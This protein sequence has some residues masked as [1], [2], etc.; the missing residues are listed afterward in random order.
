MSTD[1]LKPSPESSGESSFAQQI[2][3]LG[4]RLLIPLGLAL[5]VLVALAIYAD[6]RQVMERLREF[7]FELLPL[8]LALSLV[9]YGLRFGRWQLYLRRLDLHLPVGRSLL[10][11]LVGFVLSITPGKVGELGK[12]WMVREMDGGPARRAVAAVLAERITDLLSVFLL[13]CLGSLA[14]PGMAAIA[15]VGLGLT[16]AAV[17]LLAWPPF[18]G[19]LVGLLAKI[20]WLAQ[21]VSILVDI[22]DHL[23]LLLAPG[24]LF[25]GLILGGLAWGAEG[26]GFALVVSAYAPEASWLAGV[27]NYSLGSLAGG[28]AMLPGGLLATEGVLTALL[29][30]QGLTASAAASATLIVRAATLWFAVGLGLIALPFAIRIIRRSEPEVIEADSERPDA[31]EW[32]LLPIERLP[33]ER[34]LVEWRGIDSRFPAGA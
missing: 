19:R 30:S 20:D 2:S 31:P 6:A 5:L 24:P 17:A 25:A 32:A 23:R 7:D 27:F 14:F 8:V 12:A 1:N 28:L 16:A 29:G 33:I 18:V 4:R 22:Q 26:L 13:A 11:F 15:W 3:S 21:R 34:L 9:N 10:V